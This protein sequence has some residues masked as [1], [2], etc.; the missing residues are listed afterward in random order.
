MKIIV[1]VPQIDRNQPTSRSIYTILEYISEDALSYYRDTFSTVF[2]AALF[3]IASNWKQLRCPSTEDWI[4]EMWYIC[5]MKYC[6]AV[7]KIDMKFISK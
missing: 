5:I 2:N 1:V 7:L 4:K 6:P 3:K